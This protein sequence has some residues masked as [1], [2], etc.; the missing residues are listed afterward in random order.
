MVKIGEKYI[1]EA[2]FKKRV[3]QV[4]FFED[5]DGKEILYDTVWR[6]GEFLI[7]PKSEHEVKYIQK[8]IIYFVT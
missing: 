5:S 4:E 8:F 2:R 3:S 7:E 1:V 6:N